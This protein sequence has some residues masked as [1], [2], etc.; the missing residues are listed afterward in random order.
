LR[1]FHSKRRVRMEFTL[2]GRCPDLVESSI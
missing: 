2:S 1:A